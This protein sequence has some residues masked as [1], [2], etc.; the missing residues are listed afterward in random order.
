MRLSLTIFVIIFI[1]SGS[2]VVLAIGLPK[3]LSKEP[4]KIYS[5][6]IHQ[7]SRHEALIEF[8]SASPYEILFRSG[9]IPTDRI[10]EITGEYTLKEALD[11]LLAKTNLMYNLEGKQIRISL[12]PKKVAVLPKV[13]VLGYLR[14]ASTRISQDEDSQDKFPLYQ[15]PL[16][17]QSVSREYIE[18]VQA[19]DV[20]DI[21]AYIEGV[22]YYERAGG[23]NPAYYSRG[24][25]TVFSI[26]GKFYRRST[27]ELDPA[28]LDRVDII[29]GSSANYY[30]PGGILNFVT[31]K[32]LVKSQAEILLATGSE[33][34]YRTV[35]DLNIA[36]KNGKQ[37]AVRVI[38]LAEK[39]GHIKDF[40][41]SHKYG[42]FPSLDYEFSNESQLLVSV[43]HQVDH[44]YPNRFTIHEDVIDERIPRE[45]TLG[46]PWSE[47]RIKNSILSIDYTN[48][49]WKDWQISTGANI[50]YE[51]TNYNVTALIPFTPDQQ[52]GLLAYL[53]G[54]SIPAPFRDG[55]ATLGYIYQKDAFIK[56]RGL[57]FSAE[58]SFTIAEIP[59][60]IRV[61][62]DYQRFHNHGPN[63]ALTS[64][65][66]PDFPVGL[67][68]NIYDTNYYQLEQ[69][70]TPNSVGVSDQ[71]TDFWGISFSN[72]FY[73]TDDITL[74]TDLRYEDMQFEVIN[75]AYP[76]QESGSVRH[77]FLGHYKEWTPKIGVNVSLADTFSSHLS[78]SRSFT[79]QPIP[80]AEQLS[81]GPLLEADF[82]G[83]IK[84]NQLEWAFKKTW[85]DGGL[86]SSLTFYRMNRYNIITVLPFEIENSAI[87]F[88]NV[89]ADNQISEG[90]SVNVNGNVGDNT[91]IIANM[92]YNKNT[93]SVQIYNGASA[94]IADFAFLE[95]TNDRDIKYYGTA[96]NVAN[97][98]FNHEVKSGVFKNFRFGVGVKYIGTRFA[99]DANDLVLPSYTKTDISVAYKG[100]SDM[101]LSFS[102]RNLFDK[103]Y[104]KSS[105]GFAQFI[106][107]GDPRS[108]RL[109]LRSTWGF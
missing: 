88:E 53:D 52:Q 67:A 99:D 24:I 48:I 16:S 7:T 34:F 12:S 98:W 58:R 49:R 1:L 57:D 69:P 101:T 90:V 80:H 25:L 102:I 29:Q 74:H 95:P 21:I 5:L 61:G 20:D 79:H 45:Q 33:D 85:L 38:A 109:S 76:T 19:Q 50:N 91:N 84:N 41:F 96:K 63:Y 6:N 103:Y 64:V 15:L 82:V 54:F 66:N 31:K 81:A 77:R 35:I 3:D 26:D 75:T 11:I 44:K 42:I 51:N 27:L 60:L 87:E 56:T 22:E 89:T 97:F 36:F 55:F 62:V 78:Y 28:I 8:A 18:D 47:A 100:F 40:V 92:S 59:A 23:A 46:A 30:F 13:T 107:E 106:E 39:A 2:R 32:P 70:S 73:M 9:A 14:D 71:I 68:F 4:P 94:N 37:Q 65:P 43:Y 86:S 93:K 104:Y 72:R 83:P 108:F 10:K 105:M 17:I